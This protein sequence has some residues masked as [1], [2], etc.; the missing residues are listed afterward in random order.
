[1]GSRQNSDDRHHAAI[2]VIEDMAV[3]DEVAD[4]RSSKI[5]PHRDTGIWTSSLPK[6][7]VNRIED[8]LIFRGDRLTIPCHERE[9]DLVHVEF[10]IF[11]R[12]ILDDPILD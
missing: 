12:A 7:D 6:W 10:V 2:F 9:M 4:V 5:H 1:M 11:F 8:L 3:I